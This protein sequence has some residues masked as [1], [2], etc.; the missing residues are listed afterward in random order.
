M[1]LKNIKFS[2]FVNHKRSNKLINNNFGYNAV[3]YSRENALQA[4]AD[5]FASVYG[6]YS[7]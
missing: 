2:T 5:Y 7:K 4:F 1:Y 6:Q 3:E